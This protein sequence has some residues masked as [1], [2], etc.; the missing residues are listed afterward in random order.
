MPKKGRHGSQSQNFTTKRQI[1][2][3]LARQKREKFQKMTHFPT[4]ATGFYNLGIY[5]HYKLAEKLRVSQTEISLHLEEMYGRTAESLPVLSKRICKQFKDTGSFD[6]YDA[7]PAETTQA[8]VVNLV[9]ESY[10]NPD[11]TVKINPTY[12]DHI[13]NVRKVCDNHSIPPTSR[14]RITKYTYLFNWTWLSP[15]TV[16]N[17][18]NTKTMLDRVNFSTTLIEKMQNPT[19]DG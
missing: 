18:M 16:T 2:L 8:K 10:L 11:R 19:V 17:L 13:A 15:S 4:T 12:I 9:L 1:S 5:S 14:S 6:L 7:P 3:K